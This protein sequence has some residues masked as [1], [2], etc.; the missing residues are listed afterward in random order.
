[1]LNIRSG[2]V[3]DGLVCDDKVENQTFVKWRDVPASASAGF[4]AISAPTGHRLDKV[5]RVFAAADVAAGDGPIR[6]I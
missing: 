2:C 6:H 3:C 4:N 5:G 1:M